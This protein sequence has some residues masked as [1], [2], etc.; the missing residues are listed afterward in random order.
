M[1]WY[2]ALVRWHEDWCAFEESVALFG[3]LDT[4]PEPV[5]VAELVLAVW[6]TPVAMCVAAALEAPETV[7][8]KGSTNVI[9]VASAELPEKTSIAGAQDVSFMGWQ[10]GEWLTHVLGIQC[11]YLGKGKRREYSQ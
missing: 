8:N 1:K 7:G 3:L 2:C 10:L 9:E 11:S 4:S 6:D 5:V